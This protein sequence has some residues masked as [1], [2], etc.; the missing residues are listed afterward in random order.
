ME[1]LRA[2]GLRAPAPRGRD[3]A[4][5]SPTTCCSGTSQCEEGY[6]TA[7]L[8]E[9]PDSDVSGRTCHLPFSDSRARER[10]PDPE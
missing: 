2:P 3:P 1:D 8:V 10:S 5:A 4:S 7:E 6:W 9:L